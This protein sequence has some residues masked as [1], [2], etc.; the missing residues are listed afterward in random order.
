MT[1]ILTPG[2]QHESTV[3][4]PVLDQGAVKRSGRG[5]PQ[6]RPDRLVGDKGDT[7][8]RNRQAIRQRGMGVTI[9]HQTTERRRAPST[10]RP[11]ASGTG[12]SAW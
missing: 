4:V 9:P 10:A 6:R 1:R 2:Q 7:G 11:T 3:L 8:R 5:R 12:S